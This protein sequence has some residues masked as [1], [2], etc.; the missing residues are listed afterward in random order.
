MGKF[1]KTNLG[2]TCAKT[3]EKSENRKKQKDKDKASSQVTQTPYVSDSS[4]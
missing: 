1:H 4:F 2:E 3:K